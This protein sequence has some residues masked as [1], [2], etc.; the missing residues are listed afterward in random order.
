MS[1]SRS[2]HPLSAGLQGR[3]G[4]WVVLAV[5][6]LFLVVV[7]GGPL[8]WI[9]AAVL[10]TTVWVAGHRGLLGRRL[11]ESYVQVRAV[12]LLYGWAPALCAY[13]A[14]SAAAQ[15]LGQ[16]VAGI[17]LLGV[18]IFAVL[19]Y[20]LLAVVAVL[21]AGAYGFARASSVVV[22]APWGT[23]TSRGVAQ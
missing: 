21:S 9:V 8:A 17:V 6:L 2:N 7:M 18:S 4:H 1:N 11:L 15:A 3:L 13:L 14:A 20:A 22:H 12:D 10:G 19:L 16:G 23:G 5:V